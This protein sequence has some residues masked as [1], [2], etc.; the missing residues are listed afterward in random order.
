QHETEVTYCDEMDMDKNL[1][2]CTKNPG[3]VTFIR[4]DSLSLEHLP[5]GY[6]DLNLLE[7]IKVQADLTVKV[8]VKS[9]SS[10]RPERWPKTEKGVSFR[11]QDSWGDGKIRKR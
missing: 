5:E 10:Q 9:I 2:M 8:D 11:W 3:H 7:L 1:I 6:R 4:L